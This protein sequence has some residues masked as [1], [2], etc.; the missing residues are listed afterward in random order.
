[1]KNLLIALC[2]VTCTTS[3]AQQNNFADK[4]YVETSAVVDTLVVP[5]RIYLAIALR[6][7]DSKGKKSIE[8]QERLL[9][10]QLQSLNINTKKDLHLLNAGSN[11]KNY[12]LKAQDIHKS[13]LYSLVVG[14]AV[15]VGKVINALESAGISNVI[16]TKAEY[17]KSDQLVLKLKSIAVLRARE[18]A[19]YMAEPLN[20]KI[21]KALQISDKSISFSSLS[22][23]KPLMIR[24]VASSNDS[25]V[26]IDFEKIKFS[27]RVDVKFELQ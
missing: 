1:M 15:T 8:E 11:Y 19:M 17:S 23:D 10:Q 21:G 16:V 27:S 22:S 25:P 20:Q 13:K 18:Q 14:D 9:Q 3:V 6:E 26:D 24:G 7:S 2:L 5:D 12:L 4:P